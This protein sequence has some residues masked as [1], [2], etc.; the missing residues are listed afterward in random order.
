[1]TTVH[2]N[3]SGEPFVFVKGAPEVVLSH[4]TS[5]LRNGKAHKL[6]EN[7]RKIILNMNGKMANQALRVLG[8]AYKKISKGTTEIFREKDA[9]KKIETHLVYIGLVGMIDPPRLEVEEAI[10]KCKNAGIRIIM[11]TGD[12]LDTALAIA[13]SLDL[14]PYEDTFYLAHTSSELEAMSDEEF[15]EVL[16]DL[17]VCARASPGIKRRIVETLQDATETC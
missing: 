12:Q 2:E 1:M 7:D 8:V 10:A 9:S 13:K 16:K 4:C 6:T 11:I 17:D 15:I 14:K 3:G 5:I